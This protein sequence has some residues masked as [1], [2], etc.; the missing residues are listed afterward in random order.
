MADAA[1]ATDAESSKDARH[2]DFP[3]R[4]RHPDPQAQ[5]VEGT[6]AV[7]EF[8]VLKEAVL[9]VAPARQEDGF[10]LEKGPTEKDAW[11]RRAASPERA[12]AEEGEGQPKTVVRVERDYTAGGATS[13][14]VQFYDGWIE[15]LDGRVR[16]LFAVGRS[17]DRR[18]ADHPASVPEHAQRAQHRPR[19]GVRPLPVHRRQRPR[20]IDVLPLPIRLRHPPPKS[21]PA[22]SPR[23]PA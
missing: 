21:E 11:E 20:R 10:D 22:L 14:R 9:G 5:P 13:G 2:H 12:E 23:G 1:P 4:D 17:A 16:P 18:T 6:T 8:T 15:E 3:P 7:D 19:L